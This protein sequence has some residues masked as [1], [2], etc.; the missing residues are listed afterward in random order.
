[1]SDAAVASWNGGFLDE[2]TSSK[3]NTGTYNASWANGGFLD[4]WIFG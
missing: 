1:M 3:Y 2:T 4:F